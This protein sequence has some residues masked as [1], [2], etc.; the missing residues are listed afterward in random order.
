MIGVSNSGVFPPA[1]VKFE[2]GEIQQP[3]NQSDVHPNKAQVE[4]RLTMTR[5]PERRD[6]AAQ[7]WLMTAPA[8]LNF[9]VRAK[10]QGRGQGP[11]LARTASELLYSILNNPENAVALAE[12]G[13][14]HLQ[15]RGAVTIP[16]KDWSEM[17]VSATTD[18]SWYVYFQFGS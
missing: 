16:S 12:K 1:N 8:V 14:C 11:Y 6:A 18:L 5:R 4:I 7:G 9:W 17:L 3:L 2:Q 13:I 10:K 15:P